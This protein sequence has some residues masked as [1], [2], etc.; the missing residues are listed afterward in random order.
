MKL[1][2]APFHYIGLV[3][4]TVMEVV[5]CAFGGVGRGELERGRRASWG[6]V[7]KG[8]QDDTKMKLFK[9]L[10]LMKMVQ[11]LRLK[12]PSGRGVGA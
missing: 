5:L 9:I 10:C 7:R 6:G 11:L 4:A 8:I 1:P 2:G 3:A 12:L